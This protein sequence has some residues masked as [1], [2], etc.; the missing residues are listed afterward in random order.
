MGGEDWIRW[1]NQ[2]MDAD[3]LAEGTKTCA[4]SY[5]GPQMTWPIYTHG[6]IGHA[7]ENLE[8]AVS[9]IS[10]KLAKIGGTAHLSINKAVV[11]Q[12]SSAIPVVPLYISILFKVMKRRGIHEGCIEQM[13]RLFASKFISNQDERGRTRLDNLEMLPEVQEEVQS[14]WTEI[15]T[16]NLYKNSDYSGYKTEF[17]KLFGFGVDGVNYEQDVEL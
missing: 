7:K 6:T 14:L 10:Q 9:V 12:A 17:L 2:L 4:Y 16:E 11:T 8:S 5:I 15:S 1:M 3:V 13:Y